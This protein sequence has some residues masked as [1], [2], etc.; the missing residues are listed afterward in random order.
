[1]VVSHAVF[2]PSQ[3]VCKLK[4]LILSSWILVLLKSV[5]HISAYVTALKSIE[6][7]PKKGPNRSF[8]VCLGAEH[9]SNES[10]LH[11]RANLTQMLFHEY[12]Y[13]YEGKIWNCNYNSFCIEIHDSADSVYLVSQEEIHVHQ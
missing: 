9:S 6:L 10:L 4:T 2:I 5:S 11:L 8:S 3:T 13:A 1:M 12:T 7:N